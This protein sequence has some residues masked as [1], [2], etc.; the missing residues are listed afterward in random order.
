MSE[1]NI[2]N[3]I[4][5]IFGAKSKLARSYNEYTVEQVWRDTFGTTISTYTS[6]VKYYNGTLTVY[7]TS[8]ALKEELSYTKEKVI[9]KMNANLPYKK[10][11]ELVVR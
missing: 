3:I 10:V 1:E 6:N 11:V 2:K 4:E 9:E 7:I 8:S 5:K